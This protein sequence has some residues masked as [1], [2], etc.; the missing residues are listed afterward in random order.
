MYQKI[1]IVGK[2]TKKPEVKHISSG[3]A[4]GNMSIAVNE[5]QKKGDEYV[6]VVTYFNVTTFGKSAENAVTYLDKGSSVLV[7]GRMTEDRWED[8]EGNKRS[9]WKLVANQVKYLSAK[10]KVALESTP[11]TEEPPAQIDEIEPF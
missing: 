6:D 11:M 10:P 8:K 2:C 7:E 1:V 3:M 5:K 4:I 9:A